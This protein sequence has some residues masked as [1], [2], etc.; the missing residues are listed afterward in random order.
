MVRE[1]PTSFVGENTLGGLKFPYIN[2]K[3]N[4]WVDLETLSVLVLSTNHKRHTIIV[5]VIVVLFIN[6]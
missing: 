3:G 6:T 5:F 2:L 4:H 1:H